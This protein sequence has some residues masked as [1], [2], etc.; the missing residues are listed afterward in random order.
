MYNNGD[1]GMHLQKAKIG[2]STIFWLVLG[3]DHLPIE[4]ITEFLLHF[5][6]IN[7]SEYL[8]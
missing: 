7:N 3:D 6:N 1:H 4:P 8:L 5:K 2:Q